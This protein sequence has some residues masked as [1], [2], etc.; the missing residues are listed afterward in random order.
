MKTQLEVLLESMDA[1]MAS[2]AN[3]IPGGTVHSVNMRLSAEEK[4]L[5]K[6][7]AK[8]R[9]LTQSQYICYISDRLKNENGFQ[10]LRP[11]D[12]PDYGVRDNMY[13]VTIKKEAHDAISYYARA[14]QVSISRYLRI[15]CQEDM[16]TT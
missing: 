5:F 15:A 1:N 14:C 7:K 4:K 16:K 12:L 11:Y 8:E 9:C 2:F 6:K 13:S 3:N 10:D